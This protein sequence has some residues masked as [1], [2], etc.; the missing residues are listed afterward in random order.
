MPNH[1]KDR[2]DRVPSETL[3]SRYELEL[4]SPPCTPGSAT[5]SARASLGVEIDAVLPYLNAR[6][7]GA[8]YDHAAK[9]LVWKDE[10]RSFAFR[11]REIKAAPAQDREEAQSLIDTAVALANEAWR[12]RD[13]IAPRYERRAQPNLMQIYRLLP[14]TN[15]G[16]CGCATC[17]AFAA[18][19]RE[20]KA[21]L[22]RCPEL[23]Q[24]R[25]EDNR[26]SL[27]EALGAFES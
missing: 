22:C 25:Y 21:E 5:W 11:S 14:R 15:C 3:I 12:D 24:A 6:L 18:G 8:D 23:E 13:R 17:M 1:D 16:K 9:V 19:L 10:G 20:G 4:C 26:K 27:A 2:S 7:K